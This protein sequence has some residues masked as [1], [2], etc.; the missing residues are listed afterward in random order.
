MKKQRYTSIVTV[1]PNHHVWTLSGEFQVLREGVAKT[2]TEAMREL[3][4]AKKEWA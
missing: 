3:R 4:K 1:R 2:L